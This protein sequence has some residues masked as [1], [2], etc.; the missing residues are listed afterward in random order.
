LTPDL[1]AEKGR[2]STL[3]AVRAIAVL[4]VIATHSLSATVA[5][6]QSFNIPQSVFKFFDF[7]QF[8]VQVFFALSGWLIFSLYY[9][10]SSPVS[11]KHYW[12]RRIARIWPLWALFVL[13]YFAIYDLDTAGLPTWWAIILSLVFLGW[14]VGALV[15]IPTG[16]LTIQQ[17]M[18]HYSL[19]WLFRKRGV[20]FFLLTVIVGYFSYFLAIELGGAF[21]GNSLLVD[22]ANAWLRLSLFTSWPLFVLGGLSYLAFTNWRSHE[23]VAASGGKG[24]LSIRPR[25][26]VLVL[27]T[28]LLSTQ[29]FYSQETPSY[30][31]FGFVVFSA[32]I[33]IAIDR[34][35]NVNAVFWSIGRYSYFMYFFHFL[36]LR[37]LESF[38]RNTFGT[39]PNDSGSWN[40]IILGSMFIASTAIS[41]LVAWVSWRIFESPILRTARTKFK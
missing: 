19:F 28:A 39:D 20:D 10:K 1:P 14:T 32:L 9:Q 36:V 41:W 6:T 23:A 37:Q 22:S 16:G 29:I 12:A 11:S 17:E 15:A 34:I 13:L 40:L 4:G 21:P 26:A 30:F 5:V 7:G 31:V 25:T 8:G 18:G 27:V 3:D 24:K 38:Y 33:G 2:V 35:P